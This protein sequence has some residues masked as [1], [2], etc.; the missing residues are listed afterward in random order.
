MLEADLRA[1]ILADAQVAGLVGDRM[2]PR[3]LPQ[4]PALPALVFQRIDTRRMHDMDG[5]DGLP[6]ARLQIACW[7][8]LPADAAIVAQAVRSRMDGVKGSI[9]ASIIGASLCVGER[10]LN[11]AEAG[12]AGVALDFLIHYQED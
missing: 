8:A 7:A 4:E 2:Y 11:D 6:R 3:M 1:Y 10:D 12:R 5:A 9:G